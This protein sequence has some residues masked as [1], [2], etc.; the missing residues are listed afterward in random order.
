MKWRW[1]FKVPSTKL[2]KILLRHSFTLKWNPVL[3]YYISLT[4]DVMK[5]THP[6]L[7]RHVSLT[8]KTDY[9][10]TTHDAS[11]HYNAD[12][13]PKI[14]S[15][16]K[17]VSLSIQECSF[18]CWMSTII[19]KYELTTINSSYTLEIPVHISCLAFF[20]SWV[21][22]S[23]WTVKVLYSLLMFFMVSVLHFH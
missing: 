23:L 3:C 10:P 15:V 19:Q 9:S 18:T 12:L 16:Q 22:T 1:K 5:S 17:L 8:F 7:S 13:C 21:L 4:G 6:D 14:L 2:Q 20:W 11:W